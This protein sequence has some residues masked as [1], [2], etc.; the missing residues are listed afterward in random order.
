ML[1]WTVIGSCFA[2]QA[3]QLK[4]PN[5]NFDVGEITAAGKYKLGDC[6]Y[7]LLLDKLEGHYADMPPELRLDILAFYGDLSAPVSTKSD[8]Q[9]WARVVKE[10]GELQASSVGIAAGRPSDCSD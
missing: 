9:E 2:L 8:S 10:L 7:A 4:L 3:G 6:A 5:D 1:R